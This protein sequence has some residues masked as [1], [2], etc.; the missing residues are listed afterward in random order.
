MCI[1]I[2][3]ETQP[4]TT[5][6]INI[7]V[8]LNGNDNSY[9]FFMYINNFDLNNSNN[10]DNYN[11]TMRNIPFNHYQNSQ[12]SM[13]NNFSLLSMSNNSDSKYASFDSTFNL[14]FNNNSIMVVPF[15]VRNGP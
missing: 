5:K 10:G 15:P 9:N 3:G 8:K 13:F 4:D 11:R 7:P 1:I 6:L 14:T 12:Q 2:A